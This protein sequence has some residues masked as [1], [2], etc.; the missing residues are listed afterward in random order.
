MDLRTAVEKIC[1]FLETNL[2]ANIAHIVEKD[3]FEN[4]KKDPRVNYEFVPGDRL[5]K[6]QFMR[7]GTVGDWKNTFTVSQN[8]MFEQIFKERMKDLPLHFIWDL[9]TKT[10]GKYSQNK[11]TSMFC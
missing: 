1:K 8:E 11:R 6:P 4:M 3:T 10:N 2:D 5:I 7:K 9:N